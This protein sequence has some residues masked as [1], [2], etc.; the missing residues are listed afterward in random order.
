MFSKI[1]LNKGIITL[2]AICFVMLNSCATYHIS[3]KSLIEQLTETTKEKKVNMIVAFPFFIP[4]VVTGN[5][6]TEI[7]VLDKNEQP[8]TIKVKRETAIRITKKD[9][10][11]STFYFDT[12][13]IEDSTITGKKDHFLGINIKPINLNHI[14]KIELQK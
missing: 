1:K 11:K 8:Y 9:G 7:N 5:S 13:I 12:L 4:G 6:L 10:K 3:T 2:L 14:E